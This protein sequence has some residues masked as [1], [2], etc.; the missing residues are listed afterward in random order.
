MVTKNYYT[1]ATFFLEAITIEEARQIALL[2]NEE[3][4][5]RSSIT[6]GVL[7]DMLRNYFDKQESGKELIITQAMNTMNNT[8]NTFTLLNTYLALQYLSTPLLT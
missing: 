7:L 2:L 3:D 1:A 6:S 5:G 8:M 4:G